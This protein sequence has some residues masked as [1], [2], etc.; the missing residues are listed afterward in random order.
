MNLI[1]LVNDVEFIRTKKNTGYNFYKN[2]FQYEVYREH[3]KRKGTKI[4]DNNYEFNSTILNSVENDLFVYGNKIP[5]TLIDIIDGITKWVSNFEF[6]EKTN[7]SLYE[8]LTEKEHQTFCLFYS[9]LKNKGKP[10]LDDFYII[11]KSL[12]D[13]ELFEALKRNTK[14]RPI[15]IHPKF[16]VDGV[17]IYPDILMDIKAFEKILIKHFVDEV[18]H[19]VNDNNLA[20]KHTFESLLGKFYLYI[21]ISTLDFITENELNKKK[22]IFDSYDKLKKAAEKFYFENLDETKKWLNKL[23]NDKSKHSDRFNHMYFNV[24][25]PVFSKDVNGTIIFYK[26]ICERI[27]NET[28]NGIDCVKKYGLTANNLT[29]ILLADIK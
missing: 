12:Y 23:I 26:Y 20:I 18:N 17:T 16:S 5:D 15:T 25:Y 22:Q 3:V 10:T 4:F 8:N 29:N 28:A 11:E 1:E 9:Y 2:F 13:P 27:K 19:F 21:N 7:E 6:Y 24:K 14:Y